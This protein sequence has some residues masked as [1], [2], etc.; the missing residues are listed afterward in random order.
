MA[1]P[2]YGRSMTDSHS[3]AMEAARELFPAALD[4]SGRGDG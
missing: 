2:I 4:N 1:I 3:R